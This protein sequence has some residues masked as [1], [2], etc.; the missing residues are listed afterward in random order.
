[1]PRRKKPLKFEQPIFFNPAAPVKSDFPETQEDNYRK[2]KIEQDRINNTPLE[3]RVPTLTNAMQKRA[4]R[5]EKINGLRKLLRD[6]K[7]GN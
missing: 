2:F 5:N 7:K 4:A 3:Q 1:M 6:I